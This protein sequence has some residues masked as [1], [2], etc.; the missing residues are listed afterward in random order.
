MRVVITSRPA[1]GGSPTLM[2]PFLSEHRLLTSARAE[3]G[4]EVRQ[5]HLEVEAEERRKREWEAGKRAR[6]AEEEARCQAEAEA[7]R[8]Q[9][10]KV[11]SWGGICHLLGYSVHYL[12][13]AL[14]KDRKARPIRAQRKA[15]ALV[16]ASW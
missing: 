2:E 12:V 5:R 3:H 10:T 1:T 4:E 13:N 8:E 6:A 9:M 14:D 7:A 11:H 16:I 15:A